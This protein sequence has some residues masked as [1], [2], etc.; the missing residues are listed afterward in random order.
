MRPPS[1]PLGTL[2]ILPDK[3]IGILVDHNFSNYRVAFQT[4]WVNGMYRP[5][6]LDVIHYEILEP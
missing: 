1:H 2:V 5:W 3:S 4:C 6:W